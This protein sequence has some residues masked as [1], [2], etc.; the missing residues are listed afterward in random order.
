MA[1]AMAA[2]GG[3]KALGPVGVTPGAG[4]V[5][6]KAVA[7][8]GGPRGAPPLPLPP[9]YRQGFAHL[10]PSK[11]PSRG[12]GTGK[13]LIDVYANEKAMAAYATER[14]KAQ[15]GAIFVAEHV[16]GSSGG[17]Q[18]AVYMLMQKMAPGFDSAHG[19]WRYV[20]ADREGQSADG[21]TTY[22]CAQCH[23]EAPGDRIFPVR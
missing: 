22:A 6:S 23:D 13:Y 17:G 21:A 9:G 1:L 11:L 15:E 10:A 19:D 14:D 4:A 8:G 5:S 7:D 2:C 3:E 20:I 18:P 16:D 12:H